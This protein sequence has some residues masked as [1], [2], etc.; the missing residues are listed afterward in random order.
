[1]IVN[2]W[3]PMCGENDEGLMEHWLGQVMT[4]RSVNEMCYRMEEDKDEGY[5]NGWCWNEYCVACPA[6]DPIPSDLLTLI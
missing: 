1:M 5:H 6:I 2:K 4:I 3:N